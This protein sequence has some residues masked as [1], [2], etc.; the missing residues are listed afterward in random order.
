MIFYIINLL[1]ISALRKEEIILLEVRFARKFDFFFH[2][3]HPK[4]QKLQKIS[5]R[6]SSFAKAALK[7]IYRFSLL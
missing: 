2:Q 1:L 5:P 7:L 3:Y 6:G 4:F